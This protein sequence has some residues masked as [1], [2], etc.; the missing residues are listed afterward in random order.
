MKRAMITNAPSA[1]ILF[2][3]RNGMLDVSHENAIDSLIS[4]ILQSKENTPADA[5]IGVQNHT[6]ITEDD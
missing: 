2:M 6:G 1:A 5:Q 4:D 3:L